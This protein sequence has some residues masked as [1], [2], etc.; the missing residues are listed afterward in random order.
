MPMPP[1]EGRSSMIHVADLAR[2]LLALALL[3]AC[4]WPA[5]AHAA[6]R[7]PDLLFVLADD[8]DMAAVPYLPQLQ[9][10]VAE[11]TTLA[12]TYVTVPLCSPSRATRSITW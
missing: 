8:M 10:L 9:R 1:R 12:S 6:E 2:L 11:G 7:R 4:A 5:P 3:V